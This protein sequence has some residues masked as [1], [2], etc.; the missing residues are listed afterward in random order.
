MDQIFSLRIITEKNLAFNQIVFCAFVDLK[1]SG[2]MGDTTPVQCK[3]PLAAG[4]KVTLQRS[5]SLR[6]SRSVMSPWFNIQS[7]VKQG[8]ATSAWLFNMY[9]DN[10]LQ[11]TTWKQLSKYKLELKYSACL[12]KLERE[13]NP[14]PFY[15]CSQYIH[16]FYSWFLL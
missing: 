14:Q 16:V 11:G 9:L 12:V 2:I 4:W 3:R 13:S 8:C 1:K 5:L 7:G 6:A 15:L 10:C